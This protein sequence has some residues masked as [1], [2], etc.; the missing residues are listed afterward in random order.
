MDM[1]QNPQES[2][3]PALAEAQTAVSDFLATTLP[4]VRRVNVIKVAP[5][6][7]GDARWEAEADVWQPNATLESLGMHTD[8]PVLDHSRYLIRLDNLLNVLEYELEELVR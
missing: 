4:E 8:R 3:R 1:S 5:V 2:H 7:A 6:T